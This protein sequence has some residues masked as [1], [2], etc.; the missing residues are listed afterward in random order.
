MAAESASTASP[1]SKAFED[2]LFRGDPAAG[3]QMRRCARKPPSGE[4]S[5][6]FLGSVPDAIKKGKRIQK[7]NRIPAL[8]RIALFQIAQ[9]SMKM[10]FAA[11]RGL[12]ARDRDKESC[13]NSSPKD[14]S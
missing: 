14:S 12:S 1:V 5:K 3:E 2:A 7:G 10:P 11:D 4:A 9:H 6:G 8:S 13:G